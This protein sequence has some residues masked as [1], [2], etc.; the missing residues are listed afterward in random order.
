MEQDRSNVQAQGGASEEE[1]MEELRNSIKNNYSELYVEKIG[2]IKFRFTDAKI[3][4]RII[5]GME[6]LKG[7]TNFWDWARKANKTLND[8]A[9]PLE[10]HNAAL[11][12]LVDPNHQSMIVKKRPSII[13]LYKK[14]ETPMMIEVIREAVVQRPS[15]RKPE[16]NW[17]E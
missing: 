3:M 2:E 7:P 10:N 6:K 4:H 13:R 16:S 1:E 14:M 11:F 17:K 5:D 12:M 9:V 15:R 8:Y